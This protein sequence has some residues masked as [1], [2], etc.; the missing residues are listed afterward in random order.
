MIGLAPAVL[1]SIDI[2][3]RALPSGD[4][5]H[6]QNMSTLI[7]A[8][9]VALHRRRPTEEEA[10]ALT[11]EFAPT[12]DI[13]A[14]AID[15]DDPQECLDQLFSHVV[16]RY[17]L[18]H[19][20]GVAYERPD[21]NDQDELAVDAMRITRSFGL[22]IRSED[23]EP[24]LFIRNGSPPIEKIFALT[25]WANR[26]WMRALRKLDGAFTPAHPVYFGSVGEGRGA[27]SRAIGLPLDYIPEP[28][29][30]PRRDAETAVRGE[31]EF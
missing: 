30:T 26:A 24:G 5:R 1:A 10:E 21:P 23:Q 16:E 18:G 8:S 27:K 4:R 31:R 6:R 2:I 28:Y 29:P 14:E 3:E 11:R 7:A 15:R 22:V 25:R 19:W 20:L 12:V 9:F 13:H 17:P